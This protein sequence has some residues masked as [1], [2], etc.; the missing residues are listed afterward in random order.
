M[1]LHPGSDSREQRRRSG[2]R[3]AIALTAGAVLM[4]AS[5]SGSAGSSARHTVAHISTA[6][7]STAS[8]R[9]SGTSP[10][11]APAASEPGGGVSLFPSHRLVMYYGAAGTSALGVLGDAPPGRE[12]ARLAHTASRYARPN[13]VTVPTFELITWVEQGAPGPDSS[14]AVRVPDTTIARYYAV[15]HA[16]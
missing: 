7:P 14:Y 16:H 6:S 3:A 15:A 5:C 2:R 9:P 1:S 13:V 10:A 4:V 12:W 11:P 8:P